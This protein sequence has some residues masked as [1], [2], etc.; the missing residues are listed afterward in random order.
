MK[1]EEDEKKEE[2]SQDTVQTQT[3]MYLLCLYY[4][5]SPKAN[6]SLAPCCCLEVVL[7]KPHPGLGFHH[8]LPPLQITLPTPFTFAFLQTLT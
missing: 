5:A 6:L 4:C 2:G 1:E 8:K 7:E 3:L